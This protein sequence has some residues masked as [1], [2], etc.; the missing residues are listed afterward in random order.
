MRNFLHQLFRVFIHQEGAVLKKNQSTP[1]QV[2]QSFATLANDGKRMQPTLVH[3]I[4]N[5]LGNVVKPL[6]PKMVVDITKTPVIN[7]Y[8]DASRTT[9][10]KKIVEPWDIDLSN[11]MRRRVSNRNTRKIAEL[12]CLIG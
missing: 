2:I 12:N 6:Q 9:G 3:D 10:E 11:L 4:L 8:D 1:I 7:V 5:S